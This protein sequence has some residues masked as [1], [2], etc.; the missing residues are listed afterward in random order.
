MKKFYFA[1]LTALISL[2]FSSFALAHGSTLPG[3]TL[4]FDL[5]YKSK[6]DSAAKDFFNE[7]REPVKYDLHL[8]RIKVFF[9]QEDYNSGENF[10]FIN[11]K[12][13]SVHGFYDS[14]RLENECSRLDST[15]LKRKAEETVSLFVPSVFQD[16]L[17]FN[18]VYSDFRGATVFEWVRKVDGIIAIGEEVTVFINP[19]SLEVVGVSV[20]IFDEK[21]ENIDTKPKISFEIAKKVAFAKNPG[22]SISED[23]KPTLIITGEELRWLFLMNTE[24]DLIKTKFVDQNFVQVDAHTGELLKIGKSIEEGTTFP[25]GGHAKFV[26]V[27]QATENID[28]ILTILLVAILA[29]GFRV[30]QGK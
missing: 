13:F 23:F 10:V 3:I 30:F 2:V 12:D 6:V 25:K 24:V 19:A 11:S 22:S 18:R 26:E 9:S 27:V 29:L 1:V 15:V 14:S 5:A 4:D 16:E 28:I 8:N 17:L 7:T 21:A 20:P